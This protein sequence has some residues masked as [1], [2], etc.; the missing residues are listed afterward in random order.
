MPVKM[1]IREE[2]LKELEEVKAEAAREAQFGNAPQLAMQAGINAP[3]IATAL[4]SLL[5]VALDIRDLSECIADYTRS[6]SLQAIEQRD[7]LDL[8]YNASLRRKLTPEEV[9]KLERLSEELT[10]KVDEEDVPVIHISNE[11]RIAE[12][13]AQGKLKGFEEKCEN[14]GTLMKIIKQDEKHI[15]WECPKC[16]RWVTRVFGQPK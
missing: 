13:L 8:L 14:C 16:K 3:L 9:E 4:G 2:I 5:E 11:E 15:E 6:A 1:R 10:D 12:L 7:L